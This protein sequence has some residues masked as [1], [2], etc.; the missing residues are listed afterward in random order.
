[1]LLLP[2]TLGASEAGME[3]LVEGS[4]KTILQRR[5]SGIVRICSVNGCS[6]EAA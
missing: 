3:S 4:D 5:G 2:L 1:M 6:A